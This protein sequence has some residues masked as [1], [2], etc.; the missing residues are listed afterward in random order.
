MI[1]PNYHW[2]RDQIVLCNSNGQ[3]DKGQHLHQNTDPNDHAKIE[4]R[5]VNIVFCTMEPS[6]KKAN[7]WK[8]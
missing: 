6:F 8:V 3:Q 7:N 5:D 4:T 1:L 2:R